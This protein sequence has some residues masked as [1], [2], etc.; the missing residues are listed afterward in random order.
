MQ[1]NLKYKGESNK[2]ISRKL[3]IEIEKWIRQ[4]DKII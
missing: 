3:D 4:M 2:Y 1:S